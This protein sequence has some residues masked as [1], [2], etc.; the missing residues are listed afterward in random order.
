MNYCVIK[1]TTTII[2]GSLN[3]KEIM[4]KNAVNA[5]FTED[6]VEILTEEEYQ[7]RKELEPKPII[8]P[9]LV[10]ENRADIDYISIMIG[11][12]L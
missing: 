2:D 12:D 3:N 1:N 7:K 8:E 10:E 6:E 5:K 4:F 9:T 11:V